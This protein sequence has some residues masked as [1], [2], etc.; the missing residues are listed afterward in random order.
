MPRVSA[1]RQI[2]LPVATCEELGIHPGDDV[3]IF[4]H[5][6]QFNII[7][8]EVGSA[9]GILKDTKANK[10]VSDEESRQGHFA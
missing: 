4:R 5:G 1:K 2:T 10:S 8:K 6:N 3:E 9:A 7:K